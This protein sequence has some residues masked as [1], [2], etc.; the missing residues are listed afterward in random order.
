MV[1]SKPL[2]IVAVE[3]NPADFGILRRRLQNVPGL[4]CQLIHCDNAAAV[5]DMLDR[6]DVDC[7]FLDY[8]L[9]ACTGLDV[10]T[11]IRASGN[12]VPIITLTGQG[13]EAVAVEAM[14]RG[15]QDYLVKADLTPE[16]LRLAIDNALEKVALTRKV[17]ETQEEMRQFA[18]TAAHDL[19][20]PLRRVMQF[21]QQLQKKCEEK[22]GEE[23]RELLHYMVQNTIQMQRLIED[24]LAYARIGRSAV[25]LR[26]VPLSSVLATVIDHLSTVIEESKARID[27]SPM[28][29]VL[30]DNTALVQLFQNLIG[31]AL[32]FRGEKPPIVSV[33]ARPE[34]NF[35]HVT[36]VDNGIGIAP[37]H[38]QTIFAPFRRLHAPHEYEGSG[39][40]LAT[41]SKIVA[42]HHGQI[43]VESQLGQGTAFHLTL[44]GTQLDG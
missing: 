28:P 16:A 22:L 33:Q 26:P 41:C 12:D 19:K 1:K 25:P 40:G 23:E 44:Q 8:Q 34:D 18:S 21:C 43:W 31:N 39:I 9:G 4:D 30:G 15:A 42:Q 36:V 10:L 14:K 13:N 2:T 20:A 5:H 37:E 17:V 7:L 11:D 35:W 27:V 32:K 3:D 6:S 29:E 38:H 24:L